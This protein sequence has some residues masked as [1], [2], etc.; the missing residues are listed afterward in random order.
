VPEFTVNPSDIM[1]KFTAPEDRVV[2]GP[3]RVTDGV[4]DGVTDAER[5]IL[6][7]LIIDGLFLSI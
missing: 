7:E 3:G 5:R 6:D 2:H 1:V 4:T